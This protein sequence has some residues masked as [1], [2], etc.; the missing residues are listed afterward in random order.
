MRS[1]E[2]PTLTF[3]SRPDIVNPALTKLEST[4]L[5]YS[6]PTNVPTP[7]IVLMLG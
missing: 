4:P 2:L 3:G 6:R 1:V 7:S 5:N